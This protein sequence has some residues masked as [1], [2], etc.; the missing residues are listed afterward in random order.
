[1][2]TG[3][4]A[5]SQ[6]C[7]N[8]RNDSEDMYLARPVQVI[9]PWQYHSNID[10]QYSFVCGMF[11]LDTKEP[12]IVIATHGDA[13]GNIAHYDRILDILTDPVYSRYQIILH[14]CYGAIVAKRYPELKPYYLCLSN[15]ITGIA[16]SLDDKYQDVNNLYLF[17]TTRR[18]N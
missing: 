5:V 4:N 12:T 10:K 13:Y 8:L 17:N 14:S 6:S 11:V 1:M 7:A 15:D 9:E 2:I 18:K 3:S 16:C